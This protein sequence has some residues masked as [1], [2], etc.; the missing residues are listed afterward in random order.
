MCILNVTK[1]L[2]C[3][4]T[5]PRQ[6]LIKGKEHQRTEIPDNIAKVYEFAKTEIPIFDIAMSLALLTELYN[7]DWNDRKGRQQLK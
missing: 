7:Q 6:S 3:V 5:K 1:S 4:Q 2:S